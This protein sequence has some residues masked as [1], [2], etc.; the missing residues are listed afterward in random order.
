M[1]RVSLVAFL[2]WALL[3]APLAAGAQQVG[4]VARIAY[5]GTVPPRTPDLQRLGDEFLGALRDHGY[6]EGQNFVIE[7]RYAEGRMDRFPMLARELV[8]LNPEVIVVAGDQATKAVKEATGTIPIVMIAC[9][10]LA[11]GLVDSLSR[12]SGNVTGVT[13]LTAE[14][15][16]KRLE[17]LREIRPGLSLVAVLWNPGDPGKV[18]EWRETQKVAPGVGVQLRSEEVRDAAALA[19]AF[20]RMSRV[21]ALVTLADSFTVAHRVTIVA[22]AASH[23]LPAVYGFREFVVV[24]GLL[25]YGPSL[26][27]MLEQ[28]TKFELVINLKTAKALGLTIPPAVLARADEVIE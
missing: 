13:C 19:G 17:I 10:A 22:L 27:D 2:A 20:A 4:K 28:P 24:G 15:A 14:L 12:P 23:R 6:V 9:D 1:T 8:R 5:L 18:I 21:D 26:A 3:A 7:R 11:A 16:T 25:S